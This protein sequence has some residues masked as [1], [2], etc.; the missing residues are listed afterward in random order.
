MCGIAGILSF[1]PSNVVK[2]RLQLMTDAIKHRGPEKDGF[3][4]SES[5]LAA[6]GH[7]RLSI[8]DLSPAGDQPMHY[9]N[10]FTIT[11]NGEIYNY[12]ELHQ[13]LLQ[14]WLPV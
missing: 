5:K 8:I 9:L 4:H 1:N 7:R 14:R 3:W 6:L 2:P 10:R 11:Y 12:I 13:H